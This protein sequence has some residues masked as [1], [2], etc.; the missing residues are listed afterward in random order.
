MLSK[1]LG[2]KKHPKG[3]SWAKATEHCLDLSGTKVYFRVPEHTD[4]TS[5]FKPKPEKYNIYD[6]EIF[7]KNTDFDEPAS[8]MDGGYSTGWQFIGFPLFKKIGR[9]KFGISVTRNTSLGPLN[10]PENLVTAIN[11]YL[12]YSIG[13][14]SGH[15]KG[16]YSSRKNWFI[17]NIDKTPFIHYEK[18]ESN[19]FY[20]C[21]YW[22]TA[23]SNE[24]FISFT[25]IKHIY[26]PN[27]NLHKAY[28]ELIE[29]I[30]SSIRIEWSAE[31][32][33]QQAAAKE[34]WP[35]DKLPE[36]L[37]ELSWSD[38]EWQACESEADKE[39]RQL[40]REIEEIQAKDGEFH[41]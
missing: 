37:P 21:R 28:D 18:H 1:L 33:K 40:L 17:Q 15:P 5:S 41:A 2:S 36:S 14:I 7:W 3:P 12:Y 34:K 39:Q 11:Q 31:A 35:D 19:S 24:H 8:F 23:I 6:D 26:K 16:R 9:L 32:L 4:P 25:F 27:T 29:K 20:K 30:L 10:K 13:P 22:E 38:E